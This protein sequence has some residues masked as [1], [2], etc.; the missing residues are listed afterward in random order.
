MIPKSTLRKYELK[1]Y[2]SLL[3]GMIRVL[4]LI[5]SNIKIIRDGQFI[6]NIFDKKRVNT[7]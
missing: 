5:M 2:I 6:F 7:I 3:L 1:H 4:K